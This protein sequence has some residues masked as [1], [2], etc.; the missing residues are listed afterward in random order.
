MWGKI[1]NY[2]KQNPLSTIL[3]VALII[4]LISVIFA[5]GY[6][7]HDD[8][9]LI[10]ESSRSWADGFDYNNWL[11]A[12]QG[13]NAKPEG[14]SLLYP[15]ISFC[16]FK[17]L[18]FLGVTSL[19]TQMYFIRFIHALFSLLTIY[20]GYKI[21]NK[22]SSNTK[23]ANIVGWA[24]A[25]YWCMPWFSVRNL[26]EI[27]CIPFLLWSTWLYIK[28]DKHKVSNII[29][30]GIV[31]GIAA[32]FRFQVIFFIGGFG[33]AM[34]IYKQWK[35]AAIW[36]IAI[37]IAF[38]LTQSADLYFWKRPFAEM[39]E[40]FAYNFSHSNDYLTGSWH[41]YLGVIIGVLLPPISVL[42]FFGF[43]YGYK[44]LFLFLPAFCFLFFHSIFPNKQERFIFPILPS[45]IIL[46]VIGL[47][48][49]INKYSQYKWIKKTILI[50]FWI[51]LVLNII[52]IVPTT[53][54]YS[55]RSKV[56]TMV[57]LSRYKNMGAFA[58]ENTNKNGVSMF[59][60]GYLGQWI[61]YYE[62][63]NKNANDWTKEV[64]ITPSFF[65]FEGKENLEKRV[66]SVKEKY[67]NLEYETTIETS[68]ID[69]LLQDINRNSKNYR[70]YIYRNKD[71]FPNKK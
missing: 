66:A 29:Y 61:D 7:M 45:I 9:F 57:Y 43:L 58:I 69:Q 19:D 64:K 40:Y 39:Q 53:V 33:L 71:I 3:F 44:R 42:L 65:I 1:T 23:A 37:L 54:H 50:C 27:V 38:F 34:L 20:F 36:A 5:K 11:P 32:S 35:E 52:L 25:L 16:L 55:K 8:H 28:E 60:R 68:F 26:V 48:D 41:K 2:Y 22:V 59:P 67:P 13:P 47:Y 70:T 30:S 56:E 63:T 17:V 14:H 6:G 21:T 24:L 62:I 18:A 51:S 10:I 49:L 31:M 12:S 46:G 4:R 15:I